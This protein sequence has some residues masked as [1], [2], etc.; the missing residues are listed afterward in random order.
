MNN[1]VRCRTL[2][3]AGELGHDDGTVRQVDGD[4]AH[5]PGATN[6]MAFPPGLFPIRR[7]QASKVL[8]LPVG[9]VCSEAEH[10]HPDAIHRAGSIRI[11]ADGL[12]PRAEVEGAVAGDRPP[13]G[14][15]RPREQP[16]LPRGI[17][18]VGPD[19]AVSASRVVHFDVGVHAWRRV[20]RAKSQI[21]SQ[22]A[23]ARNER[24]I[25][26]NPTA[27]VG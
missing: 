1:A 13:A 5:L 17:H 18:A 7:R 21:A 11:H 10:R 26:H 6:I 16:V 15:H 25:K 9:G 14:L 22:S 27:C 24:Q 19:G 8:V 12:F 2:H 3:V 23:S 4:P 20:H